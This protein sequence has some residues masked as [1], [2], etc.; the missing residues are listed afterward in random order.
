MNTCEL[1]RTTSVALQMRVFSFIYKEYWHWCSK[2]CSKNALGGIEP[3]A[4]LFLPIVYKDGKYKAGNH[5]RLPT[6]T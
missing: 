3:G 1:Q 2:W 6:H 4:F 5:E